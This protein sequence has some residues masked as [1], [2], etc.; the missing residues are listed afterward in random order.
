M[1]TI[2]IRPMQILWGKSICCVVLGICRDVTPH[3][4][5][6]AEDAAIRQALDFLVSDLNN[7]AVMHSAHYITPMCLAATHPDHMQ[8][9]CWYTVA[10]PTAQGYSLLAI[11]N[12]LGSYLIEN[13]CYHIRFSDCSEYNGCKTTMMRDVL[14]FGLNFCKC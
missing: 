3:P 6:C 8:N 10:V 14:L 9:G 7:V 12:Y 11:V 13:T 4:H 1:I 5:L 2:N